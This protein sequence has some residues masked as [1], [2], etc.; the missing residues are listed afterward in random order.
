MTN[1]E[2]L[3]V[4]VSKSSDI[5]NLYDNFTKNELPTFE[6]AEAL[7]FYSKSGRQK[8]QQFY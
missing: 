2:E 5:N 4:P 7:F 1:R 3:S 8:L 6:R